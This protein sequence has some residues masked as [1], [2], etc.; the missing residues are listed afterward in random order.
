[1]NASKEKNLSKLTLIN[2]LRRS[3]PEARGRLIKYLNSEG[4]QVLSE[5]VFNVLFNNAPLTK[6]QKRRVKKEYSKEKKTLK[7]LS[8]RSTSLRKKRKMLKQTGGFLGTL[9]G[10]RRLIANFRYILLFYTSFK[11]WQ[12]LC[13]H[14]L[15]LG[16]NNEESQVFKNIVS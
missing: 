1:M 13:C 14:H 10:K 4:I 8:K 7:E 11:V 12:S 6:S 3:R 9:L 15:Y 5:S 2:T 16:T